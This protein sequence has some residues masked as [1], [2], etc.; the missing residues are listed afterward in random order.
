MNFVRDNIQLIIL[1]IILL[2]YMNPS[3]FEPFGE[4]TLEFLPVGRDRYGLRGD[5]LRRSDIRNN[6]I[7]VNRQV[8]LHPSSGDMYASSATPEEE[9]IEGCTKVDCPC[10][11]DGYKGDACWSCG[12]MDQEPW[13]IPAMHSH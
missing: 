12:S 4:N 9:G 8:R 7:D 13:K 10:N 5:L 1:V 11:T 2:W 3:M 6:Y